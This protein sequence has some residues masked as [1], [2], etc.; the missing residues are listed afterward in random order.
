MEE[1][2]IEENMLQTMVRV[3]YISYIVIHYLAAKDIDQSRNDEHQNQKHIN[4]SYHNHV[5]KI[6]R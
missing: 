2:K 1:N 5:H 6:M 4:T 3:G